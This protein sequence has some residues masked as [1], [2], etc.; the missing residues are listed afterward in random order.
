M[1][2]PSRRKENGSK[3]GARREGERAGGRFYST[4]MRALCTVPCGV[5]RPPQKFVMRFH[6]V[7]YAVTLGLNL[8]PAQRTCCCSFANGGAGGAVVADTAAYALEPREGSDTS[9]RRGNYPF[10]T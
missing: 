8:N 7:V 6:F 3:D 5:R 2:E 4:L 1:A 10:A 9:S